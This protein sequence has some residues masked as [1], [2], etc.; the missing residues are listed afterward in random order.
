[1]K[2]LK[3]P[4]LSAKFRSVLLPSILLVRSV[5]QRFLV[6]GVS[7][8]AGGGGGGGV[9]EVDGT[10]WRSRFVYAAAAVAVVGGGRCGSVDRVAQLML[11]CVRHGM[12]EHLN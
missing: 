1:M 2:T 6:A 11:C 3:S 4:D 8:A 5:L 10:V 7:N 9:A 12:N